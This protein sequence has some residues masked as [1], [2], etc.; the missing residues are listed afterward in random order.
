MITFTNLVLAQTLLTCHV[1]G[2][3]PVRFGFPLPAAQVARGLHLQS[4]RDAKFQWSLLQTDPDPLT[5]RVWVEI[6]L[7]AA[8]GRV[9]ICAGGLPPSQDGS[10]PVVVRTVKRQKADDL[11]RVT[12]TWVWVDGSRD[13]CQQTIHLTAAIGQDG[14]T[15]S[16]GEAHSIWSDDFLSR[17]MRVDI[18]PADWRRAGVLPPTA[19]NLGK[20]V[21][22]ELLD[23]LPNLREMAGARGRGDYARR[24]DIVTNL[25][26]D[27]TLGFARLALAT[28]SDL[29]RRKAYESARHLI[30]HDLD[31]RSGLPFCHGKDHRSNR[32]VLGHCWLTGVLLTGCVFADRDLIETALSIGRSLADASRA[33]TRAKERAR[34][35]G[36]PLLELES[37]LRFS[38]DAP[39]V[40]AASRLADEIINRWDVHNG[41]FRFD[42]G[43]VEGKAYKE[44]CWLTS[45]ILIP[46]LEAYQKRTGD[47]RVDRVVEVTRKRITSL[48][49]AGRDG[50]PLR[51]M[52]AEGRVFGVLRK[53]NVAAGCFVLEGLDQRR[54]KACLGRKQVSRAILKSLDPKDPD[55]PTNFAM[56]ARCRWV[57]R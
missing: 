8:H 7:I 32:P 57:W 38:R 14:E 27:M 16:S 47:A 53:Q 48:L 20:A 46:A 22:H 33:P 5:G 13:R 30:D 17:S 3:D 55:L 21:R 28:R 43:Q 45:G 54:Q 44:R 52:V 9:Q 41:V 18:S 19:G 25:E 15:F 40:T 39:L 26:F 36:W 6:A 31:P 1:T 34:A 4:N 37:A 11:E 42:E 23:V 35:S 51:Y 2:D 50:I 29:A 10:G 12:T 24:D 56:I 49:R